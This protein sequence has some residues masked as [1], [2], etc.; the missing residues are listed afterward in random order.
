MRAEDG[1]CPLVRA[2][3]LSEVMGRQ[4]GNLFTQ[5]GKLSEHSHI[6]AE[7]AK[8]KGNASWT[9]MTRSLAPPFI[10]PEERVLISTSPLS[11]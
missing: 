4:E 6:R 8:T 5:G 10:F 7:E 1:A 9:L 11:S 2:G 3:R